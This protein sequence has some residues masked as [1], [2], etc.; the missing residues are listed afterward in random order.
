MKALVITT[1]KNLKHFETLYF[2][3]LTETTMKNDYRYRI[4]LFFPRYRRR[5][6]AVTDS[7]TNIITQDGILNSKN[8]N[9][10]PKSHKNHHQC[11]ISMVIGEKILMIEYGSGFFSETLKKKF[12]CS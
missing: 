1:T 5:K 8:Q 10:A 2:R 9:H 4:D 6:E 11:T 7:K 12:Y 3:F